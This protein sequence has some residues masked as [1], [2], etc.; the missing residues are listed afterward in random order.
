MVDSVAPDVLKEGDVNV[1]TTLDFALQR[2]AD[3]TVLRHIAQITQETRETMGPR[4]PKKRRARSSRSIRRRATFA[5]SCPAS[6]RSA[7]GSIAR[8]RRDGNP[9]RRSSRSCTRRRW[10][11]A[12]RPRAR[13]TTIPST[14]QIGRDIWQPANYNNEYNGRITLRER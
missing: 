10:P 13:W 14:V 5:R 12:I 1:Y 7:A 6:A 9:G 8:S 4:R 2:S 3:R 11:P